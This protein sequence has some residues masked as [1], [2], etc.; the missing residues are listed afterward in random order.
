MKNLIF[1]VFLYNLLPSILFAA[2]EIDQMAEKLMKLRLEVETLNKDIEAR[3]QEFELKLK[4]DSG[5]RQEVET[6]IKREELRSGQL[7]EKEK[8]FKSELEK[9]GSDYDQTIEF[10]KENIKFLKSFIDRSPPY[11]SEA[12]KSELDNLLKK[13][14]EKKLLS[15]K[16]IQ[17]LWTMF[18]DEI[19]LS[20]EVAVVKTNVTIDGQTMICDVL[21]LGNVGFYFKTSEGKAGHWNGKEMVLAHKSDTNKQI[22]FLIESIKKQIKNTSYMLPEL[23]IQKEML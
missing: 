10:L 23:A 13:F 5:L 16:A 7:A 12:R 17:Q 14:E 8:E 21:R 18:E 20:K 22:S 15:E 1:S 11:K 19:R 6:Q 4:G 2:T 9:N 3:K